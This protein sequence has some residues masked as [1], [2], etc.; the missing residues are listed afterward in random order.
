VIDHEPRIAALNTVLAVDDNPENL[1]VLRS[2]LDKAG[3]KVRAARDGEQALRSARA[4]PPD[5]VLLDVHMPR[6]DGY[7]A[8]KAFKEDPLLRDIPVLFISALSDPF[9][10]TQ[11]FGL[12][13]ID[14]LE[15]PWQMEDLVHRIGNA[16]RLSY[17]RKLCIELE[18]QLPGSGNAPPGSGNV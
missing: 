3:F 14:Y 17:Y 7:E 13:A 9:N 8:C 11:A 15:K 12:G 4:E 6:M 10:K 5:A 16:I 2:M 18:K 1:G